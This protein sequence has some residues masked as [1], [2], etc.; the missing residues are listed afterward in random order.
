MEPPSF[1]SGNA[2]PSDVAAKKISPGRGFGECRIGDSLE[3]ALARLGPPEA[4]IRIQ[5]DLLNL[6]YPS[7]GF[8]LHVGHDT[9][10]IGGQF[11]YYRSPRYERFPGA[12]A[13]GIG[14]E[15]SVR[16]VLDAYGPPEKEVRFAEALT[17]GDFAG[18]QERILSYSSRGIAFVFHN[19]RL[20][21]FSV[22]RPE[23]K[24]S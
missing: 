3:T 14:K 7:S 21:F 10:E 16:D 1:K 5:F 12:T 8:R 18:S 11:F 4:E 19:D 20:S 6:E 22:F 9:K 13:E 24:R 15:S 2:G 23:M 17:Q